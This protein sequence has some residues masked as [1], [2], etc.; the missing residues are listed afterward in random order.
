[1]YGA[2]VPTS[3][4]VP[5]NGPD[6]KKKSLGRANAAKF[7]TELCKYPGCPQIIDKAQEHIFDAHAER[8]TQEIVE[9]R[10]S[11]NWSKWTEEFNW[12]IETEKVVEISFPADLDALYMA[13]N[14][15]ANLVDLAGKV[16]VTLCAELEQGFDKGKLQNGAMEPLKEANLIE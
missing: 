3:Q 12:P 14:A 7:V 6:N 1:M 4:F 10:E 9:A 8:L 13:W 16:N 15:V 5:E 2:L 11:G